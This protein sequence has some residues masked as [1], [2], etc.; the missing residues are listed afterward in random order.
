MSKVNNEGFLQDLLGIKY[1]YFDPYNKK[2][3]KKLKTSTQ[4]SLR[5]VHKITE[6]DKDK[7]Y[8]RANKIAK[9]YNDFGGNYEVVKKVFKS[10][11][12]KNL[13]IKETLVGVFCR[14]HKK[15][16]YIICI[17]GH[18]FAYIDGTI[19]DCTADREALNPNTFE[20]VLCQPINSVFEYDD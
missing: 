11:G 2:G 20:Y 12:F 13:H 15:G 9:K 4:C 10:F 7:I 3:K 19:Y 14:N 17:A 18:C 8:K 16:S 1:E 6:I 5:A